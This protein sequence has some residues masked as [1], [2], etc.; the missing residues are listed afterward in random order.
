MLAGK[1]EICI[2]IKA[3]ASC[4][5]VSFSVVEEGALER[6]SGVYRS[7]PGSCEM[8]YLNLARRR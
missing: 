3:S 4:N 6:V 1:L 2:S 8:L 5:L 7:F